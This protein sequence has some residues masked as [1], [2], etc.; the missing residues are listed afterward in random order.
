MGLISA[1]IVH[2]CWVSCLLDNLISKFESYSRLLIP[3]YYGSYCKIQ[4]LYV[5][6]NEMGKPT[7]AYH[8]LFIY[9]ISEIKTLNAIVFPGRVKKHF[10]F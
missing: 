9:N 10:I 4:I 8:E 3:E 7:H 1:Q 6:S 5:L 2:Y